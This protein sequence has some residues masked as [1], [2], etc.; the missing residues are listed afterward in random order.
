MAKPQ[1]P[2]HS[3]APSATRTA[4]WH[5]GHGPLPF[6]FLLATCH[7]IGYAGICRT[8]ASL[9]HLFA[10]ATLYTQTRSGVSPEVHQVTKM[11]MEVV[12][13]FALSQRHAWKSADP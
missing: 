4:K 8:P 9:A 5:A 2:C 3:Q 12:V 10:T 13:A 7:R 1:A 6:Y 11:A